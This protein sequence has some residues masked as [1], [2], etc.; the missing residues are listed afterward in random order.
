MNEMQLKAVNSD[1][2]KILV[3]AG[4][5]T[6]K[7]TVLLGRI[8][9]LIHDGVDSHDILALTFTNAAACEMKERYI[10]DNSGD[11]VP[12]FGTFH[13]FCYKLI[14]SDIDVRIRLGYSK[15]PAVASTADIK[16][17][18]TE[19]VQQ[20][21]TKLSMTKLEGEV[22]L[23]NSEKFQY[24]IFWK[25][26]NKNLRQSGLI[27][28]DIMC[29]EVCEL[30][31]SND[32]TI[33][34]YKKQFKH[35][36]VDEFQDTDHRQ[37]DFVRSFTDSSIFVVGDVKQEL[38][39]FRNA[40]PEI[41]K[42]LSR[43]PEW[44]TIKLSENYRCSNQIC[45]FANTIHRTW[46]DAPYNLAITGQFDDEPV[47]V[48]GAFSV[49]G[50]KNTDTVLRINSALAAD[51]SVAI[52]CRT[53][54]EVKRTIYS[55]SQIGIQCRT[56]NDTNIYG[57]IVEAAHNPSFAVEWLSGKLNQDEYGKYLKMCSLDESYSTYEKFK[58]LYADKFKHYFES[59]ES[60][61]AVLESDDFAMSKLVRIFGL[62]KKKTPKIE[63]SINSTDEV[64]NFLKKYYGEKSDSSG[65]YVGTIHS[66]KGLEY[67]EVHLIGVMGRSFELDNEDNLNCFYV[68]VT[69]AKSRLYI[70]YG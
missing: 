2:K 25:Q 32:S 10:R 9:R 35:I 34:K 6:G 66:V 59:I 27:T 22:P 40:D 19:C 48:Y 1:S 28:F 62:F 51:K 44:E 47:R 68:G 64:V 26:Y 21:G 15:I 30:F 37:W 17:I 52:L 4:A 56:N 24:E 43:N 63:D 55:L 42:S 13:S 41:I 57:Y 65:V 69:R 33:T 36:F 50:D 14:T 60:V 67:D 11:K 46:G 61:K 7:S 54:A 29:Y 23:L 70:Y 8:A 38:Y 18:K 16:R 31:T 20:C 3:L 5:G 39:A 58:S 45:E 12:F 49:Y 53:N